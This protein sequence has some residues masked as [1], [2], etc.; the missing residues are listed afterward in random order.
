[1]N[2]VADK[3]LETASVAKIFTTKLPNSPEEK[4]CNYIKTG[5]MVKDLKKLACSKEELLLMM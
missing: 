4:T 5:Q 1:M 2:K 3:L